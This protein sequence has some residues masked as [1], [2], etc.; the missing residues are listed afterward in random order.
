MRGGFSHHVGGEE[1]GVWWDGMG[2]MS[3]FVR[4]IVFLCSLIEE[5][6]KISSMLRS[7]FLF[8]SL[9]LLSINLNRLQIS[10]NLM[11]QNSPYFVMI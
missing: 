10:G 7:F 2:S 11:L 5:Q 4:E 3:G 6:I 9:I 8:C 1:G